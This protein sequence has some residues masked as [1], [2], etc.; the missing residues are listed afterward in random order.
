MLPAFPYNRR[1]SVVV[2][3]RMEEFDSSAVKAIL[4]DVYGTL[5]E[6]DDKRAPFGQLIQIGARQGRQPSAKDA[7]ILMGQPVGLREAAE[8][9]G[10]RLTDADR[11]RLESDLRAELASIAPFADTLPALYALKNRGFPLGLCSNL[12]LDYAAPVVSI[13]PFAL[14]AY[15]WS[16]DTG[17]IKPDPVIYAHACRQ[18]GC[19]PGEVL[20]VGDT[21][22]ADVEGPRA[23]GMQAL[24]LDRQQ[25]SGTRDALPSLSALCAMLEGPA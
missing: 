3:K 7:A 2:G 24:L 19:A 16:F 14:D 20:M 11:E 17:A 1:V 15:V 21:F 4:F 6:I 23:F 25:R 12:A 13:L 5:V 22:E 18:L 9:F 10:I 8:L